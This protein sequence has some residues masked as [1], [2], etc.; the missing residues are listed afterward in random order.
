MGLFF[1]VIYPPVINYA[2]FDVLNM[3]LQY[4]HKLPWNNDFL[5][6]VKM[7]FL[8]YDYFLS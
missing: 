8:F 4:H 6:H 7:F 5:T 3:H 2:P 1:Q